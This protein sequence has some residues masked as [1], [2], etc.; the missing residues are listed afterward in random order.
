MSKFLKM[1]TYQAFIIWSHKK[2]TLKMKIPESLLKQSN[3]F[4]KNILEK[5]IAIF[6]FVDFIL[7]IGRLIVRSETVNN[8]QKCKKLVKTSKTSK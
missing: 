1:F 6:F 4:Y 2:T 5:L 8:K 3:T 7:L